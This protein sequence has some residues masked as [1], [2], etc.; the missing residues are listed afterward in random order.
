MIYEIDFSDL[1]FLV[2]ALFTTILNT[3][4]KN[5]MKTTMIMHYQPKFRQK[6]PLK[7]SK[8]C[9]L[10]YFSINFLH[11]YQTGTSP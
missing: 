5:N 4:N 2:S 1:T 10:C 11:R 8:W 9:Q 6:F 3:C 7:I